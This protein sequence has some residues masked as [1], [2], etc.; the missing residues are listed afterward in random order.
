VQPH[1]VLG[2]PALLGIAAIESDLIIYRGHVA[3]NALSDVPA[4][5]MSAI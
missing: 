1:Q 2:E 4:L 5:T 3:V